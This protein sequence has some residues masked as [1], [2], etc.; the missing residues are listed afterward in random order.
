M[1]N[2]RLLLAYDGTDFAGWQAQSGRYRTVQGV[3]E[4]AIEKLTGEETRL[5][6]AGRTDAGVHALGQ[7]ASFQTRSSI[8]V[9]RWHLALREHLP[10]DVI[11]REVSEVPRRFHA[12]YSPLSKRYRYLINNSYVEDLFL[13]R[14]SWRVRPHLD[15]EAMQDAAE[16]LIGTYDFRSF[17]SNWPN[18]NTSVRTIFDIRVYRSSH[19]RML[20]S[21]SCHEECSGN[22]DFVAVEVEADGFLYN[23][24]RIITGTLVDVGKGLKTPDDVESIRLGM[25]RRLAGDTSPAHGLFLVKVYYPEE[26]EQL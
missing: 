22:D 5:L 23:M 4:E 1:K 11:I 10:E 7:V 9:D 3:L 8:P 25:D 6:C 24:V 12:T 17:E 2:L 19:V 18:N 13:R 26:E 15:V 20:Q 16:R 14:Y 21:F